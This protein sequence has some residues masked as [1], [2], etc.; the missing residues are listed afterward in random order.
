MIF[1]RRAA[2]VAATRYS[3]IVAFH[4]AI[5]IGA[6]LGKAAYGGLVHQPAIEFRARA[7]DLVAVLP[8][9]YRNPSRARHLEPPGRES[10]PVI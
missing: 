4:A 1:A 9:A 10:R 3:P 2:I 6:P 7:S 8:R 5:V